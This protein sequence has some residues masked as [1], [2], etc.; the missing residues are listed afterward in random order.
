[1]TM[2]VYGISA[3]ARF[4]SYS[5]LMFTFPVSSMGLIILPKI[6]VVRRMTRNAHKEEGVASGQPQES[7]GEE[8]TG[9]VN[10]SATNE[11]APTSTNCNDESRTAG[12]KLNP[13]IQ[14]VTFD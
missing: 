6:L 1:M 9:D 12:S 5:L 2:L 4:V 14:V 3:D 10:P 7:T 13:R 11:L 8:G